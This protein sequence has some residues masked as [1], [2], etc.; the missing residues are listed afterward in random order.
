M[1]REFYK[2]CMD[3]YRHP[4]ILVALLLFFTCEGC[5]NSF[6]KMTPVPVLQTSALMEF[7][8]MEQTDKNDRRQTAFREQCFPNNGRVATRK[9]RDQARMKRVKELYELDSVRTDEEKRIAGLIFLHGCPDYK[10]DDTSDYLF[11]S[12]LFS[13]LAQ[14]GS[15]AMVKTNGRIYKKIADSHLDDLKKRFYMG[16][17]EPVPVL[18]HGR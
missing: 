16:S 8:Y 18:V 3:S 11:S 13:E 1:D 10:L 2:T 17:P 15:T 5:R 7:K 6:L 4:A 14:S 9:L 12:K